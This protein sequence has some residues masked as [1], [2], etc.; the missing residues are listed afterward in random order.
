M[1]LYWSVDII[2]LVVKIVDFEV[3]ILLNWIY[4]FPEDSI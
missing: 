3:K 2:K 4:M 1:Q